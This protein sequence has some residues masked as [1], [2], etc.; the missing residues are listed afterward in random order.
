MTSDDLRAYEKLAAAQFVDPA[1]SD[2]TLEI[3]GVEI[4]LF[5]SAKV[6]LPIVT[7]WVSRAVYDKWNKPA[8]PITREDLDALREELL[9]SPVVS[10][11]LITEEEMLNDAVAT[12]VSE[13]VARDRALEIA[14]AVLLAARDTT[15]RRTPG[16]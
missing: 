12:L 4:L 15:R 7:G 5:V 9:K 2:E 10:E 13:G 16:N 14:R 1:A 11:P 3:T 6:A 8:K